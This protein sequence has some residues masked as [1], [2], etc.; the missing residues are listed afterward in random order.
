MP[1]YIYV[2]FKTNLIDFCRFHLNFYTN[3]HVYCIQVLL[4]LS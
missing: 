1:D 3:I 2:Y 4:L